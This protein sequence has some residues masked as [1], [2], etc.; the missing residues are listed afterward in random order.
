[1]ASRLARK[2]SLGVIFGAGRGP[3]AVALVHFGLQ[4]AEHLEGLL[5]LLPTNSFATARRAEFDEFAV[6]QDEVHVGA[7]CGVRDDVAE[8]TDLPEPGSP[9][10]RVAV[11]QVDVDGVA[12]WS[13]P[14]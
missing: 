11:R 14:R 2:S 13:M 9:P 5:M 12:A 7:Q 10:S 4:A 6:D 3:G 8:C 1:M